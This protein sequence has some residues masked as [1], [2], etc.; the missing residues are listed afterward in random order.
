MPS[1]SAG[2]RARK[3]VTAVAEA[4]ALAGLTAAYAVLVV[5][6]GEAILLTAAAPRDTTAGCCASSRLRSRFSQLVT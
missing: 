4:D 1:T 5:L 3:G 6:T 2:S